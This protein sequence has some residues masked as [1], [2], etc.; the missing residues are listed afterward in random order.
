[1]ATPAALLAR[2]SGGRLQTAAAEQF[3][4]GLKNRRTTD[5]PGEALRQVLQEPRPQALGGVLLITDGENNSGSSPLEAAQIAREQ[6]VP[7]SSTASGDF[8]ARRDR[9]RS[10]G[11]KA[12]VVGE[13][14]E[15]RARVTTHSMEEQKTTATLRANASR[16]MS[17]K[18]W[19]AATTIRSWS[20]MSPA[21]AGVLKLE[22]SL[23]VLGRRRA[24]RTTAAATTVRVTDS[25]FHVL[26]IEQEPRW[27]FRSSSIISSA[28]TAGV[29][30]VMINGEPGLEKIPNSPFL[31]GLPETREASSRRRCS[32]SR[33]ESRGSRRRADAH[34]REW[35]EAAAA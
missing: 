11:A 24:R 34:D 16:W 29:Q 1:V 28:S 23:P 30:C 18:S 9:A 10:D 12:R 13:R 25:K 35:V 19:W 14:L 17:A 32:S 31:A 33:R 5:R 3:F 26:L 6:N 27:D 22:V 7:L 21:P 20:S 15:V 2:A 8:A 4:A